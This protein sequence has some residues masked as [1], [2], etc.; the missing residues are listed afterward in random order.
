MERNDLHEFQL[1]TAHPGKARVQRD[2][3]GR[4]AGTLGNQQGRAEALP[5]LTRRCTVAKLLPLQNAAQRD[6]Q[7]CRQLRKLPVGNFGL[8]AGRRQTTFVTGGKHRPETMAC[9]PQALLFGPGHAQRI[10]IVARQPPQMSLRHVVQ[11]AHRF[12]K[13]IH[14]KIVGALQGL[15]PAEH[16]VKRPQGIVTG[17]F[18]DHATQF[19]RI[20]QRMIH[21]LPNPGA[22]RTQ[23][24]QHLI[25]LGP[26]HAATPQLLLSGSVYSRNQ[27]DDNASTAPR[28]RSRH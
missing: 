3:A 25:A 2:G 1:R 9:L 19:P 6:D 11:T 24:A 27:L 15:Q 7:A 26:G 17:N 14:G 12:V 16:L 13:A 4:H 22:Q 18:I 28:A 23:F 5:K 20:A 10:K 21:S 8:A